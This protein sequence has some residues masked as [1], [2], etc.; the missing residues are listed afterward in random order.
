[1]NMKM[2]SLEEKDVAKLQANVMM[3]NISG[4][5]LEILVGVAMVFCGAT[6]Y[7]FEKRLEIF[8]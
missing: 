8:M 2:T 7:M 4:S 6:V 5:I 1:M 3:S